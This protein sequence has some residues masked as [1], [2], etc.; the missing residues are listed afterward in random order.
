MKN[1]RKYDSRVTIGGVPDAEDL[2]QLRELGYRTLVDLRDD[3]EKFG[4]LVQKRGRDLGFAYIG[5]PIVRDEITMDQ[6][7]AFYQDVYR[8]GSAPV[9]CFSRHGKR[10]LALLL[11]L[12]A[13]AQKKPLS[14]IF[15]RAAKFGMNLEGDLALH[16]F[17]TEF[18]NGGKMEPV[19][20]A[21]RQLRPDLL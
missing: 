2:Q 21:I 1:A 13:V 12:D 9:Y 5:I 6:V 10:P 20:A 8:K 19:V 11:L 15:R 3:D 17:L 18:Y 4:G 16:S 14:Y 7:L